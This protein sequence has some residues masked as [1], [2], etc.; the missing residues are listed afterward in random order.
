[1][2]EHRK[3]YKKA[4][5]VTKLTYKGIGLRKKHKE[6]REREKTKKKKVSFESKFK[7]SVCNFCCKPS[8]NENNLVILEDECCF[9]DGDERNVVQTFNPEKKVEKD[10]WYECIEQ[11]LENRE[12]YA[13]NYW[14][15]RI[16]ETKKNWQK[17]GC[18][19]G[20]DPM[21]FYDAGNDGSY[22]RCIKCDTVYLP[23]QY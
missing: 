21:W 2:D 23:W 16:D 7:D 9:C 14:N 22:V 11:F 15:I 3:Q 10:K 19:S 12:K 13:L 17:D 20:C 4:T 1:M 8:Y 5:N 18:S 6:A